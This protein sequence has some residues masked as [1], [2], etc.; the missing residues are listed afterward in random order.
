MALNFEIFYHAKVVREDIVNLPL[1]WR[2]KIRS[3]VEEKLTT[4]PDFYGKPLRRSL[5]GYRKLRVGDYRIVFRINGNK[6]YVLAIMHRSV[7]YKKIT[8]RI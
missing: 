4:A 1:V 2:D 6:V 5:K 7:V 8:K 3:M